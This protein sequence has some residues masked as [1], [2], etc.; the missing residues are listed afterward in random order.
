MLAAA[1]RLSYFGC[2]MSA[3]FGDRS[4]RR[5]IAL[6]KPQACWESPRLEASA[7]EHPLRCS[8][9]GNFSAKNFRHEKFPAIP[10]K[11]NRSS[12]SDPFSVIIFITTLFM[13]CISWF[14]ASAEKYHLDISWLRIRKGCCVLGIEKK[15]CFFLKQPFYLLFQ[16]SFFS[17]AVSIY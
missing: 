12:L 2:R 7:S 6:G 9:S 15:K 11:K 13:R 4:M 3:V 16:Q 1:C 14:S 5:G 17:F 8:N 10:I